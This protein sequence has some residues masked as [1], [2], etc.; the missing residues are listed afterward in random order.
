MKKFMKKPLSAALALVLVLALTVTAFAVWP[1]YQGNLAHNGQ[2][3]N[4]TPPIS[5]T[6][7]VKS[8]S[9]GRS[10]SS[11]SMMNTETIDGKS[12]V[13]AY[14][15]TSGGVLYKTNCTAPGGP[16]EWNKS[17]AA[18]GYQLGSPCLIADGGSYDGVYFSIT[19]YFE[20][21]ENPQFDTSMNWDYF[22]GA[23][24]DPLNHWVTMPQG[25]SISQ[26]FTYPGTSSSQQAELFSQVML[27]PGSVTNPGSVLYEVTDGGST[28]IASYTA[29]PDS[30]TDW[31]EV[32]Q[33]FTTAMSPGQ[34][35][36][37]TVTAAVGDVIVDHVDFSYQT[38]G[39][40]KIDFGGTTVTDIIISPNGGQANTPLTVYPYNNGTTSAYYLYYGTL[41]TSNNYFQIDLANNSVVTYSGGT[42]EYWAGAVQVMINNQPYMVFGSDGGYLHVS[43]VNDFSNGTS[44]D[45]SSYLPTGS[46]AGNVRA[47]VSVDDIG[48]YIYF[49]SQGGYLWRATI[50]ELLDPVP[51][52][53]PNPTFVDIALPGNPSIT[54][55]PAISENGIIYTGTYGGPG[56]SGTV[57][58]IDQ[59]TFIRLAT[60]YSG[61][62]VQS[63]PIVYSDITNAIDYIYF[64]TNVG[65]GTGYCYYFDIQNNDYDEEWATV[66]TNYALQ[67]FAAEN[68]Y[69]VFGND[70][71]TLYIIN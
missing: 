16:G 8:V 59:A 9:L 47:T 5:T 12:Y 39:I 25:G 68:G 10:I 71:G 37:I 61:D 32:E 45:L 29:S 70:G 20:L 24:W 38:S 41:T 60:I 18:G 64:T 35:Y 22:N 6:P 2:I 28:V 17:F 31:T 62:A 4:G 40:E 34:G 69:L 21:L 7:S 54:S 53:D 30:T 50:G 15:L 57:E 46:D 56:G 43:P 52:S 36:L 19:D 11:E 27:Q 63:S 3:T 67:G 33:Y 58:A 26:K 55:T 66:G 44:T 13:F 51:I 23:K 42:R 48:Q 14:T 1:Q 65:A 49:T